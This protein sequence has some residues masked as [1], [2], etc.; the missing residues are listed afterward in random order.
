MAEEIEFAASPEWEKRELEEIRE[1]L[2]RLNR[3]LA[4]VATD[5][6][7]IRTP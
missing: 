7:R 4:S 6:I 3:A 2:E 1:R 5:V